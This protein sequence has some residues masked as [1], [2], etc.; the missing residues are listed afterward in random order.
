MTKD[1]GDFFGETVG[2]WMQCMAKE[3]DAPATAFIQRTGLNQGNIR[4]FNGRMEL[5]LCG[6]ATLASACALQTMEV[7]YENMEYTM[8]TGQTL[9]V[10]QDAE[11]FSVRLPKVPI[12]VFDA[13]AFHALLKDE[14]DFAVKDD[15]VQVG[16][17]EYDHLVELT[18]SAFLRLPKLHKSSIQH[19]DSRGIIFTTKGK[20]DFDFWCRYFNVSGGED[21][22]TGSAHC[23]LGPYWAQKLGKSTLKSHQTSARGAHLDVTVHENCI[24]LC[25]KTYLLSQGTLYT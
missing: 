21:P 23:Y 12:V 18:E 15:I 10:K 8:R 2:E 16:R 17:N 6:H 11:K 13:K 7:L 25:G 20:D 14:F 5:E 4:W 24:E 9:K 19:L 22:A 1:G 3:L